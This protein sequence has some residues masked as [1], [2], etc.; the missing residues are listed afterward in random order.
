MPKLISINDALERRI[1]KICKLEWAN[2]G[3]YIMFDF[4]G[5]G[6]GPWAHLYSDTNEVI[7]LPNPQDI[8]IMSIGDKS[9]KEWID[10]SQEQ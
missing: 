9:I 3:D 2:S 5:D 7:G 8:L 6:Y 4:V 10:K 1:N